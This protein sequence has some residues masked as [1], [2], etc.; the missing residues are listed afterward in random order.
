MGLAHRTPAVVGRAVPPRVDQQRARPRAARQL[1]RP[2]RGRG[3]QSPARRRRAPPER[4]ASPR[5]TCASQQ[6]D[7]DPEALTAYTSRSTAATRASLL[8]RQRSVVD[9]LSRFSFMGNGDG[10]L[11][12]AR[13]LLRR[14]RR[15]TSSGGPTGPPS[16]FGNRSSTTWTTSCAP[17]GAAPTGLPFDFN[18]GYRRLLGYELKARPRGTAGHRAARPTPRCSSPTGR[19]SSTTRH[20]PAICSPSRIAGDRPGPPRPRAWLATT[21][22]AL[23]ALRCRSHRSG[24]GP[25]AVGPGHDRSR[26]RHERRAQARPGRLS[27][28]DRRV[29][30][31]DHRRRVLRDLPDQQGHRPRAD[32]A[33]PTYR[34]P[35]P[36]QPGAVRGL[37]RLRRR[38]RAQLLARALPLVDRD[39]AVEA[40]PIKGTGP[41]GATAAEDACAWRT[42]CATT[43][44]TAPR[45]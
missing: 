18:L 6:L 20:G 43:P 9:G 34:A 35:A 29:P 38:G 45:T 26:H 25:H 24:P 15:G 1:P 37:P 13:H 42:S 2:R 39:G 16:G 10:P 19:S 31:R 27:Q 21:A 4:G 33:V 17:G 30:R 11:G 41:A 7:V 8:A 12:R 5:T 14:R 44:R 28:A 40:R 36:Q 22:E 3:R 23:R 32:R